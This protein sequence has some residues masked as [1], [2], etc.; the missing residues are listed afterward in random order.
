VFRL[1]GFRRFCRNDGVDL[2]VDVLSTLGTGGAWDCEAVLPS[3]LVSSALERKIF[4]SRL[5]DVYREVGSMLI[6]GGGGRSRVM[7]RGIQWETCRVH[8]G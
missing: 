5:G 1:R 4:R 7:G 8:F 6:V 2:D 3:T